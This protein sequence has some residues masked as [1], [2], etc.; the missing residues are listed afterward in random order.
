MYVIGL[1]FIPFKT[2]KIM[3]LKLKNKE[4]I[5]KLQIQNYDFCNE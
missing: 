4:K 1:T 3:K 5:E 2:N